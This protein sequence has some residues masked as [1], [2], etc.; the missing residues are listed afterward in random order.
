[1]KKILIVDDHTI[2]REGVIRLLKDLLEV[3]VEFEVAGD[4]QQALRMTT[5]ATYDMVL[6]DISLPDQSGLELLKLMHQNDPRLPILVLSTYPEEHY[7]LRALRAGALGYLNKGSAAQV[8]KEAVERVIS[9]KKYVTPSQAEMLVEAISDERGNQPVHEVLSDR[10]LQLVKMMTAGKTLTEIAK[11]L[12]LSVK[13]I[14]TYRARILDK[15]NLRT[16]ADIISFGIQH[17]LTL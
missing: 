16:T 9:G 14:S 11:E 4:A 12:S 15:L 6:V 2:V 17:G 5:A 1:M 13:T 10:E 3:P 8:L 7:A